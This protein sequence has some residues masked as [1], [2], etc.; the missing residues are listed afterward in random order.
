MRAWFELETGVKAMLTLMR[1]DNRCVL[2]DD[3]TSLTMDFWLW[4][5]RAHC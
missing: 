1:Y 4:P 2:C 3:G 5:W